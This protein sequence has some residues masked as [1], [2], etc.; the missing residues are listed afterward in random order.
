MVARMT[1]TDEESTAW[2]QIRQAIE[3]KLLEP[4]ADSALRVQALADRL[5]LLTIFDQP[6]AWER[7]RL[8]IER[9]LEQPSERNQA[10]VTRRK[11]EFL[12]AI[13]RS[14]GE[15]PKL[16]IVDAVA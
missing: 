15:A 11:R 6:D 3:E 16:R 7:Y 13:E 4:G 14:D 9:H 10:E 1:L 2:H 5:V 12:A 8:A